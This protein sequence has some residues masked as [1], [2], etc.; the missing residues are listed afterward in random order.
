MKLLLLLII[1]LCTASLTAHAQAAGDRERLA[2]ER[3]AVLQRFDQD[4]QACRLKFAATGCLA[5]ARARRRDALAPLRER[6][7]SLAEQDRQQRALERRRAVAAKQQAAA[8]RAPEMLAPVLKLR[9]PA[10]ASRSASAAVAP[11]VVDAAARDADAAQRAQASARRQV[12][13]DAD[14]QR[15]AD[16]VAARASEGKPVQPLPPLPA[17]RASQPRR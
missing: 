14:Q 4:A 12:A 11:R 17:L 5:D 16:R 2:G 15:V 3:Q 9:Q 7:L 1:A 10:P 6:E 8:E 13:I